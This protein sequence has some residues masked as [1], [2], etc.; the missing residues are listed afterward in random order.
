MQRYLFVSEICTMMGSHSPTWFSLLVSYMH[1][2]IYVYSKFICACL[3]SK[4]MV[5][6]KLEQ[7]DCLLWPFKN[8][9]HI[10]NYI[11]WYAITN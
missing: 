4:N 6:P 1:Y 10:Q 11:T 3:V 2:L 8:I 5:R 7:P 9:C